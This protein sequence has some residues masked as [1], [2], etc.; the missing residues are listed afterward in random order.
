MRLP[1]LAF[2]FVSFSLPSF[3]EEPAWVA[4]S[5]RNTAILLRVMAEYS[6]EDAGELGMPGLDD[7]ITIPAPDVP[8]RLR[9]DLTSAVSELQT[10]LSNEQDPLVKQDLQIL[11]QAGQRQIEASQAYE[12]HVLPY[13]DVPQKISDGLRVLLNAQVPADRQKAAVV[14]LRRY[15]G[16]EAGYTPTTVLANVFSARSLTPP[17]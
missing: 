13:T 9:H 11:M 6:P 16:T 17:G 14:R 7:R 1:I 2:V 10:R 8:E 15:T 3:T 4:K 5:N 12:Q